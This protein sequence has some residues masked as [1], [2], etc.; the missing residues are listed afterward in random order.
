M[1][2]LA[3]MLIIA[4]ACACE[5]RSI[6]FQSPTPSGG[7]TGTTAA[8]SASP[9]GS[10]RPT[11]KPTLR[12]LPVASPVARLL[13]YERGG[14]I[15]RPALRLLLLADGRVISEEPNGELF[16]RRL[17]ANGTASLLLQAIQTGY[18]EKDATYARE[19]LPGSTPPAH[20]ATFIN[21]IVD[22]GGRE[23]H[24]S[25]IPTGQPDDNLYQPSPARDKISALAR[26]FEDLSWLPASSWAEARPTNYSA[27]F[28]R[29]F[30]IP[31]PNV[32]PLPGLPDAESVWPFTPPAEVFGEQLVTGTSVTPLRCGIVNFEDSL[33]IGA[34]LE[35]ARVIPY[36]TGALRAVTANL[37]SRASNGSLTLQLSPLL[38]HEPATC[39]GSQPAP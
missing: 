32:A 33:L 23:V 13:S 18:F 39:A 20:G 8:G 26:S 2:A 12:P 4:L 1:K 15:G 11:A 5:P 30:V 31:Q 24:V 36:Y 38:P 37:S 29:V 21:F 6:S 25:T 19:P 34:A 10:A 16:Y 17:T 3:A 22:N 9:S 28:F 35:R 27:Q 14:D 7:A